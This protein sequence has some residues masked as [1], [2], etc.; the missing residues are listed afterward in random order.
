M[1]P[2][3][4]E[5]S[6]CALFF[7]LP[8]LHT[9]RALIPRSTDLKMILPSLLVGFDRK[10]DQSKRANLLTHHPRRAETRRGPGEHRSLIVSMP[11]RWRM[12]VSCDLRGVHDYVT[13]VTFLTRPTPGAPRRPPFPSDG[14][15]QCLK[16]RSDNVRDGPSLRSQAVTRNAVTPR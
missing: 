6:Y 13:A 11:C 7:T 5:L 15:T 3:A 14:E 12:V 10:V 9:G 8:A 2:P 4:I 1:I 16:V